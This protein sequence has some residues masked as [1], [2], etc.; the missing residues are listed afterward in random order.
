[1]LAREGPSSSTPAMKV[2]IPAT[3]TTPTA[4]ID[5]RPVGVDVDAEVLPNER[6]RS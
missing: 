4:A 1:M 2:V 3:A 6:W 5:A